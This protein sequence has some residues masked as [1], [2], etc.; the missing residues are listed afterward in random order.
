MPWKTRPKLIDNWDEDI[1]YIM[2]IDENGTTDLAGIRRKIM[3]EEFGGPPVGNDPD[4][5]FTIT[6]AVMARTDFAAFR[7]AMVSIKEAYWQDGKYQYKQGHRRVVF[8]S[9][10]IRKKEGPFNPKF[11][12]VPQLGNDISTMIQSA[13]F[14]L[15]SSS[16]DKVRHIQQYLYPYHVYK[17]C[18]EFI[19]E[20]YARFLNGQGKKGILWLESRGKNEDHEILNFLVHFLNNGNRYYSQ[21]Q[22][23]CITGVYFNPKW[24]HA[25]NGQTSFVLLELSDLCSYPIHKFVKYGTRD[26][27]FDVVEKKMYNYPRYN[28]YGLK[29]FP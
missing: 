9:R 22:L 28:R 14:K 7:D 26:P 11:I 19:I 13:R 25:A 1:D 23:A 29:V 20:R 24:D 10:D 27:A 15:F 17:L 3:H 8:H 21:A 2:A 16:I 12:N 6:G 5:W 4:R 18:L